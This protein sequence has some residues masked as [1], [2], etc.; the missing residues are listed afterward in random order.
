ML[1]VRYTTNTAEIKSTKWAPL[2]GIIRSIV[3]HMRTQYHCYSRDNAKINHYL[4][5]TFRFDKQCVL[6]NIFYVFFRRVIFV[7]QKFN[8]TFVLVMYKKMLS[9]SLITFICLNFKS[10]HS[11]RC[12]ENTMNLVYKVIHL[13]KR[14]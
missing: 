1:H 14:N 3:I 9:S 6:L 2:N 5:Q 11:R 8:K 12:L 10:K 4:A 13:L 7:P